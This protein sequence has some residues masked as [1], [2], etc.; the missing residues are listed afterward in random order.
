MAGMLR[1]LGFDNL[2][3]VLSLY[4]RMK[5]LVSVHFLQQIVTQKTDISCGSA[6]YLLMNGTG[7]D[8]QQT[9]QKAQ[10]HIFQAIWQSFMKNTALKRWMNRK[11]T[12][13][14]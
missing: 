14:E 1:K 12:V 9:M 8:V 4:R 13:A 5:S 11:I 6:V 10:G 3:A 7:T 2:E